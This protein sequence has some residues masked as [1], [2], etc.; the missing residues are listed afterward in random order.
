MQ[1]GGTGEEDGRWTACLWG[2]LPS[3][4]GALELVPVATGSPRSAN[5]WF[6]GRR[7]GLRL[8]SFPRVDTI[9][10]VPS[11]PLLPPAPGFGVLM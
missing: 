6:S 8:G 4:L 3:F 5:K 2:H 9:C 10:L 7:P 1:Q 11:G